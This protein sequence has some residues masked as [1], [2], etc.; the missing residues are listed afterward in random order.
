[1]LDTLWLLN[2]WFLDESN[3]FNKL[4]LV[5]VMMINYDNVSAMMINYNVASMT[6]NYNIKL[7]CNY[8]KLQ[9]II[10]DH[11]HQWWHEWDQ[12]VSRARSGTCYG[13]RSLDRLCDVWISKIL[14]GIK[15]FTGYQTVYW[16]LNSLM[17]IK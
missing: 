5:S 10:I 9:L 7:V 8:D 13:R 6:T 14:L 11:I 16:I 3:K 12:G 17:D 4:F 1:M 15:Q 2:P